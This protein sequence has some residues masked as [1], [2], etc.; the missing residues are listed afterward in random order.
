MKIAANTVAVENV[1]QAP[2]MLATVIVAHDQRLASAVRK[3]IG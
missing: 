1:E 2:V 3:T